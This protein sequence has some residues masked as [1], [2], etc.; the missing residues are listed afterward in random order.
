[1]RASF[2]GVFFND[3]KPLQDVVIGTLIGDVKSNDETLG[4]V[5]VAGGD[6][7]GTKKIGFQYKATETQF[8]LLSVNW[9][10]EKVWLRGFDHKIMVL[11]RVTF[12]VSNG[13]QLPAYQMKL[14]ATRFHWKRCHLPVTTTQF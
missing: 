11:S 2:A 14:G 10:A 4:T 7:L 1:M 9:D 12:L 3:K 5:I 8:L 13:N 6:G